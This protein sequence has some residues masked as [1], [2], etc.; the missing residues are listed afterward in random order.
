MGRRVDARRVKTHR[1]YT[2]EQLADR[3]DRTVGTVRRWIKVGLPCQMDTRPYLIQG[4]DFKKFH[5]RN[6]AKKSEKL[7]DFEVYCM[8][9]KKP[10]VPQSGLV[11]FEPMDATRARIMA[12]CPVCEGM[13]RRI[14]SRAVLRKWAVKFGFATNLREYA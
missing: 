1:S 14:I 4:S 7:A 12:I 10:R 8:G 3:T 9:C 6:L 13:A 5:A 2:I 11:D